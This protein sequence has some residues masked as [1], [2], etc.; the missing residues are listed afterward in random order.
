MRIAVFVKQVVDV[1]TVRIDGQTGKPKVADAPVMNTADA[2]AVNAAIDLKEIAGGEITAVSLG[3]KD[4]LDVLVSALA[5][6]ADQALHV[7]S[8]ETSTADSLATAQALA[9][10]V[11]DEGFDVL[12]AGHRSDDTETAQVGMQIA[13]VLGIPHLSGVMTVAA[14]GESL[15]VQ[16]DADGFPEVLTV[17][18][19]VVLI[20]KESEEAP[21]RHP[22]L[23][24][25]MQAKRKLVREVEADVP[26][27]SALSWSEPMGQR[28][29]AD[30]ILLEG[31]P[32]EDA[33]V[34]LAA[35]L[36]EHR[37]VG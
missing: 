24:G 10:A 6:G 21:K 1:R 31:V 14:D 34:Q 9:S 36:R 37:L 3:P 13:E 25:M 7:A 5:T 32:A 29:S 12:I 23:R 20:T 4:V 11:R 27:T 18:T 33:A 30:R 15:Q 22:S 28:V 19:P 17:Q 26:M 35:W 16:R 2:H 8:D